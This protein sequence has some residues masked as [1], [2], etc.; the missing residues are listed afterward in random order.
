MRARLAPIVAPIVAMS[1]A[2][3]VAMIVFPAR[4]RAQDAPHTTGHAMGW[5]RETFLDR[6]SVV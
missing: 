5:G 2:M 1:V 3:S 4:G 6:K